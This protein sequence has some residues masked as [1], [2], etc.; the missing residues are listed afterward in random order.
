M[1][2]GAAIVTG[3]TR[4]IGR[5]VAETLA[6]RGYPIVAVARAADELDELVHAIEDGGGRCVAVPA[7]LRDAEAPAR[8]VDAAVREVGAVEVLVNNAAASPTVGP[9][10]AMDV[11]TMDLVWAVNVRAP[12]LL[13]ARFAE[14]PGG[15][16][17]I[18][19]VASIGGLEP[20][21]GIGLYN[22]TKAALIHLTRQLA[23]EL[24]PVRVNAVSP[25]LV[26]TRFAAVLV[27]ALEEHLVGAL[28]L[29]RIGEPRDVAGAVAFL[30]SE[31]ASWITGSNLVV[32]GGTLALG[33]L[34]T[35]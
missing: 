33:R 22:A 16:K 23:L 21:P 29:G 2:H 35:G 4:G 8:V 19:N 34:S 7:N 15:R 12:A 14:A 6:A 32:D 25:G 10:A 18:V 28:P 30:V 11:G 24:A 9:I 5:A 26:R 13:A 27:E 17:A 1:E 3:A 31:E 20:E